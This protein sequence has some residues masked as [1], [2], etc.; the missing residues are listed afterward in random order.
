MKKI[1]LL[2]LFILI[3]IGINS[4]EIILKIGNDILTR[5]MPDNIQELKQIILGLADMHNNSNETIQ[6]QEQTIIDLN[7]LIDDLQISINSYIEE[8]QSLK[9]KYE[10]ITEDIN[11]NI[12]KIDINYFG[13]GGSIG[14]SNPS[15]FFAN[16]DL[17]INI[18]DIIQLGPVI[19]FRGQF[20]NPNPEFNW[21]LGLR[22]FVWLF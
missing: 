6:V 15:S 4:Q 8:I 18:L 14:Y 21:N 1:F 10:N 22:A 19:G 12:D 7:K 9:I 5:E 3:S 16:I 13:L 2:I 11:E 20:D 17:M